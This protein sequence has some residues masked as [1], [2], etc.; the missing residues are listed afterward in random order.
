VIELIVMLYRRMHNEELHNLYASPNIGRVIKSRRMKWDG[1]VKRI[2]E[3]R[4]AYKRPLERPRRRWEDNVRMDLRGN[5]VGMCRLD[6]SGSG[7]DK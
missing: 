1:H 5:R 3:M 2:G 7:R 6:A 4:N